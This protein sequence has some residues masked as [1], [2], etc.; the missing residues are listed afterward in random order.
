VPRLREFVQQ[1]GTVIAI[2]DATI[3]GES[4]GAAVTDALVER[5]DGVVRPLPQ[6]TFFIPGSVLRVA[7][8]NAQP[9]AYGF[10]SQ[11]D[12]MF[13]SSPAFTVRPGSPGLRRAAWF[14]DAAPLRSGWASGQHRLQG[15]A[16]I[17]DAAVGRGRVL[18]FGPEVTFRAQAH[19]TFKFLF[20]GI[21]MAN[22]EA[23]ATIE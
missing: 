16:A 17:V 3:I 9:V 20:N 5:S 7:V 11:V 14:A 4:L 22:A 1:G 23:A 13:D 15:A 6:Q 10:E 2:G 21:H 12:V 18:L 8:D 19:G